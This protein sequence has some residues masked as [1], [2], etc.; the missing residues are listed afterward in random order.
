MKIN[1]ICGRLL[2]VA[3]EV[4][5]EDIE[6]VIVHGHDFFKARHSVDLAAIPINGQCFL[7]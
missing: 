6:N 2:I 4:A 7:A 5:H 3:D 1:Q